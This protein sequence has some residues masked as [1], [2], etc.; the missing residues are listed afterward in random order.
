MIP[1][2]IFK[3]VVKRQHHIYTHDEVDDVLEYL[4]L[5]LLER[6]AIA[7][8]ARDTAIPAQALR[9]WRC[10]RKPTRADSRSPAGI[11]APEH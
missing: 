11:L 7:K 8:I 10:H 5:P 2:P 3:R 4:S 6:G 9:H 1:T